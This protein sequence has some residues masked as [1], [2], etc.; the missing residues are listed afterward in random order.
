MHTFDKTGHLNTKTRLENY[1]N[2]DR[3]IEITTPTYPFPDLKAKEI[4]ESFKEHRNQEEFVFIHINDLKYAEIN[5]LC[6]YYKIAK[7]KLNLSLS[8]FCG[9]NQENIKQWDSSYTHWQDMKLWELREWLSIF[10]P[11]WVQELIDAK[12]YIDPT[13]TV[14]TTES[15]LT[16][17]HGSIYDVI[18]QH[19]YFDKSMN[20]KF[21]KFINDWVNAQQYIIDEYSLIEQIVDAVTTQQYIEWNT[22]SIISEA[23]IQRKLRTLGYEIKCYGLDEFPTDSATLQSLLEKL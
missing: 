21:D 2:S 16:N 22:I 13:W 12:Q 15:I 5:M 17:T 8:V 9:D 4:I 7:G 6:Q 18:E 20:E 11:Q 14:L 19:T 10:Y 1:L 3:Q 23:I